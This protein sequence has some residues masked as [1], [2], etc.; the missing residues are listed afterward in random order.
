PASQ[1]APHASAQAR[2]GDLGRAEFRREGLRLMLLG[3]DRPAEAIKG[4]RPLVQAAAATGNKALQAELTMNL[5]AALAWGQGAG[6]AEALAQQMAPEFPGQALL[7]QAMLL[8]PQDR[9]QATSELARKGL[10]LL[11]PACLFDRSEAELQS[12][13]EA[14]CDATATWLGLRLLGVSQ[15]ATGANASAIAALQQGVAVARMLKNP[16][17]VAVSLGRLAATEQDLEQPDAAR[18]HLAQALQAA[19]G[20]HMVLARLKIH[21][22]AM[23]SLRKARS[24]QLQALEEALQL[25]Q[26]VGAYR[27]EAVA[28]SNLADFFLIAKLPDRALEQAR[29]A[30]PALERF[31]DRRLE[32]TLNHN[33]S[34][35]LVQLHQYEAARRLR[36]Q[37]DAAQPDLVGAAE[38]SV[39]LEELADAWAE[40]GQWTDALKALVAEREQSRQVQEASRK[41]QLEELKLRYDSDRKS[42]ELTLLQRDGELKARQV[43]NSVL[44]QR[45]G[46]ALALLTALLLPLLVLMLKKVRQANRQ[47][48]ANE[49]LLRAQ[50]ERDPLTNLANR[51]HFMAVMEQHAANTFNGALLMVDIDHF[52]HVN[53]EHGHSAGDAVI[54]EVSRRIS[55]AVR[56]ED[57]VVR[58]G[59]EEF[60]VFV[61]GVPPAQLQQMAERILFVVGGETVQTPDG[62]LHVTVSVGFA[63]FPLPPTGLSL[64][65]EQAVNWADMVL[66]T[67]KAQGRNR[68][69]GIATIDAHDTEAL[70]QIQ[71][72]FDAACISSRVQ[73][74]QVLGPTAP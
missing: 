44:A 37:L 9:P 20:E 25:A 27:V 19:Q 57:L 6:E 59:G 3:Y 28:R 13:I 38:R 5:A 52:K 29:L 15:Q 34:L 41:A 58:W 17:L 32:R 69:I 45:V 55:Q 54:C 49:A 53:D 2:A 67:A 61:P 22:A 12:S 51:R 65:W 7:I 62:P 4:L 33:M 74:L 64:H 18:Q 11:K 68:A 72:D 36:R 60:L 1:A 16:A 71:A 14:G 40:T 26:T 66:Y 73:L 42:A 8:D 35:A 63:H 30:L 21:E 23:A 10:A 47:L 39:E 50:S 48:K 46:M 24:N 43:S 31:R 56:E 70:T